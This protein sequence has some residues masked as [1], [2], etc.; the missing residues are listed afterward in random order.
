M[1]YR[2]APRRL[3]GLTSLRRRQRAVLLAF[4]AVLFLR[5]VEPADDDLTF[6]GLCETGCDGLMS[7]GPTDCQVGSRETQGPLVYAPG[8]DA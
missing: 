3:E 7:G 1:R 6:G 8:K 2:H 4:A 5:V